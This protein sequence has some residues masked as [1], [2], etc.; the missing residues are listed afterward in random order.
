MLYIFTRDL[1]DLI[2]TFQVGK[3]SL[4]DATIELDNQLLVFADGKAHEILKAST[5]YHFET[6]DFEF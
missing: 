1:K 4:I 6:I 2:T 5:S 3:D